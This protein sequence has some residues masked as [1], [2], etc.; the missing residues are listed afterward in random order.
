M[1]HVTLSFL[2]ILI[3][4]VQTT[5]GP[6]AI[7]RD[8]AIH[9]TDGSHRF[10][11]TGITDKHS[12][13]ETLHAIQRRGED[14]YIVYGSDE[15]SRGWPPKGGNCGCGLEAY[16]RWIHVRDGEIVEKKDGLYVSCIQNR[17][18]WQIAWRNRKLVWSTNGL[19]RADGAPA[20]FES[21]DFTWTFDPT[22]PEMGI[23]ETERI[24]P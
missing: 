18:G 2:A 11:L 12:T 23:V 14:Y 17:D 22:R 3:P 5:A 24:R 8:H 13:H 16:I 20:H 7:F 4:C 6:T 15:W 19:R 1:K 9:V 10:V 21:V